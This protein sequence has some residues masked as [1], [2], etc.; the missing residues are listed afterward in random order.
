MKKTIVLNLILLFAVNI[1]GQINTSDSTVQVIGYWEKNE[2][3]TYVVEDKKYKVKGNDTTSI[4]SIKYKV[5]ITIKDSTSN[6]YLIDWRYYDYEV[7]TD[8]ELLKSLS[9][10]IKDMTIK[11]KTTEMGEF[12]EI[13]NWK[14]IRDYM[15]KAFGELAEKTKDIPNM[16]DFIKSVKKNYNSKEEIT[17]ST[18]D[19][20]HQFYSFHGAKYKLGEDISSVVQTENKLGGAPFDT[21][22]SVWLDEIIEDEN[23]YVL[24]M[25]QFVNSEQLTKAT[26]DYL[27]KMTKTLELKNIDIDNMPSI[28]NESYLSSS[29]HDSGW[30]LFSIETKKVSAEDFLNVVERTIELQ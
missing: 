20:M 13:L 21:D 28:I 16:D 19:E 23:F 14:D 12:Q 15:N 5:D 29:I 27:K 3:Q 7:T 26:I 18:I 25:S 30:I 17:S 8:N 10:L 22:I 6:S 9:S 4:S 1:Y 11:I 2:K 24:R